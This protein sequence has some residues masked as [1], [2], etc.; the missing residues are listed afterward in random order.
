MYVSTRSDLEESRTG[1]DVRT[2]GFAGAHVSTMQTSQ[3]L[4]AF[5][6]ALVMLHKNPF[7]RGYRCHKTH[8]KTLGRR[9]KGSLASSRQPVELR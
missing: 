3:T 6:D 8:H 9:T 2:D 7:C 4:L 5:K 1:Y